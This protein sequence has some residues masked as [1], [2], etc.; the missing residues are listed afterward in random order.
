MWVYDYDL[1]VRF[2]IYDYDLWLLFIIYDS[3]F[4]I[5]D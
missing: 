5:C 3:W 2:M 4:M 1:G